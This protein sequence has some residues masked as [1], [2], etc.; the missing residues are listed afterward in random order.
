VIKLADLGGLLALKDKPTCNRRIVTFH[1]IAVF[2]Q[3]TPSHRTNKISIT[4]I[5]TLQANFARRPAHNLRFG[6]QIIH[7]HQF[8][9]IIIPMMDLKRSGIVDDTRIAGGLLITFPQAT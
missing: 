7:L 3:T 4:A 8:L 9:L 6:P 2:E 1:T 5:K